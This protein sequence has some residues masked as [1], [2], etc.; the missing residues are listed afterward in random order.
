M[1]L[2]QRASQQGFLALELALLLPILLFSVLACLEAMKVLGGQMVMSYSLSR[3]T[4]EVRMD[5]DK[6]RSDIAQRVRNHIGNTLGF[7]DLSRLSIDVQ[8]LADVS[9]AAVA[10]LSHSERLWRIELSY[11]FQ[12]FSYFNLPAG[13]TDFGWRRSVLLQQER[14]F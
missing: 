6:D 12:A 1:T 14:N 3:M 9:A 4:Y 5:E 7:V 13:L 10:G 8:P 2:R 11:R